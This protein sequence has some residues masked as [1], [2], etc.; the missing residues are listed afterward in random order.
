[1]WLAIIAA[2]SA[3][4]C[5]LK[6]ENGQLSIE[7][8]KHATKIAQL[9]T[10][11]AQSSRLAAERLARNET[12]AREAEKSAA[13]RVAALRRD[14]DRASSEL[15]RLRV[16]L[17]DYTRPRLT[18][19]PASIAPGLDHTD[20]L[21]ELFLDCSRR[22]IDMAEKADGHANDAKTLMDAWPKQ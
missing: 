7:V 14:S 6:L 15:E 18:A 2:L 1:V 5:K 20:P 4:S 13:V 22:Y 11:I 21:P 3:T 10:G 8:E 9:E 19:S 12:Q 16:T 17:A